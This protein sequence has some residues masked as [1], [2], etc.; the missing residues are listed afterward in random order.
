MK[1]VEVKMNASENYYP[2]VKIDNELYEVKGVEHVRN[3]L[4]IHEEIVKALKEEIL[5][6]KEKG[7]KRLTPYMKNPN[8]R[9]DLI[10]KFH[11]NLY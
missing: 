6:Q 4:E 1:L 9:L 8:K 3:N 7:T 2:V 5:I 10:Q 11:C